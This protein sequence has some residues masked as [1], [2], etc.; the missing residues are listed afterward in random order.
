MTVLNGKYE[1]MLPRRTSAGIPARN[2]GRDIDDSDGL[3]RMR[4]AVAPLGLEINPAKRAIN[5]VV[6]D[7]IE[8]APKDN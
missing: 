8:H 2:Q 3:A 4:D 6:I 7:H 5:A 1:I